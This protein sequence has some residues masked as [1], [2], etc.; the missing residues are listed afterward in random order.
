MSLRFFR[1]K[2][3]HGHLQASANDFSDLPHRYSLFTDGMVPTACFVLIQRE[4]IEMGNIENMSRGPAVVSITHIRRDSLFT[5]QLD[6]VGDEALLEGVVNLGKAHHRYL[7]AARDLCQTCLF[8][9]ARHRWV[10]KDLHVFGRETP[11]G[12][13]PDSGADNQGAV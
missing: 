1:R 5:S 7:N 3:D 10:E 6:R 2:P 4:L 8:G 9:D 13:R 11:W 12:K